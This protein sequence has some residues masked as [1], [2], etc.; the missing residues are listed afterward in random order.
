ML[1]Y[2]CISML[3][4]VKFKKNKITVDNMYFKHHC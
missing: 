3:F 1:I 4:K 2:L